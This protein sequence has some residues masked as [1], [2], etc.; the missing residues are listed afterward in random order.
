[1]ARFGGQ[2]NSSLFSGGGREWPTRAL[3]SDLHGPNIW[4][5][6]DAYSPLSVTKPA[7]SGR[8]WTR[9]RDRQA[10]R[11]A[12]QDTTTRTSSEGQRQPMANMLLGEGYLAIWPL[13]RPFPFM[14]PY[15]T[16]LPCGM[17][18]AYR[19]WGLV[20]R[21]A[22][23]FFCARA[24]RLA[25]QCNAAPRCSVP[26]SLSPRSDEPRDAGEVGQWW[27]ESER[28]MAP[29]SDGGWKHGSVS[30]PRFLPLGAR[31]VN[32]GPTVPKK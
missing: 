30:P 19:H 20:C 2:H 10:G 26:S 3:R 28:T 9:S 7:R 29:P 27:F 14:D 6:A 5:H 23:G 13:P 18:L 31:G 11:Q 8:A 15:L 25:R 21:Q 24:P 22:P 12:R 4:M 17:H 1:M 32:K 16:A